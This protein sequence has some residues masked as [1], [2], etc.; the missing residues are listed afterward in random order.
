MAE[1]V[2]FADTRRLFE[3]LR[4]LEAPA[5]A[6]R[7][8]GG[9]LDVA[10]GTVEWFESAVRSLVRR[11]GNMRVDE[12]AP[13]DIDEWHQELQGRLAPATANSYLRGLRTLYSRLA[14]AGYVAA[15]PATAVQYAPEDA[16]RPRAMLPETFA[17]LLAAAEEGP[18]AVRDVAMLHVLQASGCRLGELL[19]MRVDRLERWTAGDG[20]PAMALEVTGKHRRRRPRGARR[21]VYVDGV[22]AGALVRWLEVRPRSSV[23]E[24]F[25]RLRG[26]GPLTRDGFY[27]VWYRLTAG[28]LGGPSNPTN[29]HSLRHWFAIRKLDEGHDLA[30]VSAWLGHSD[31]A[32]TASVYVVR[33]EDEL[34]R[35]FFGA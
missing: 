9:V 20:R 19:S 35:A 16:R 30:L 1:Q 24:L 26:E 12:V 2:L 32:F 34:R 4:L 31:P 11:V 17:A 15:N 18:T 22:S 10:P 8:H 28:E 5:E 29:P 6:A 14:A 21:F 7:V 25:V 27:G 33:R 23:P 3:Q 13:Q